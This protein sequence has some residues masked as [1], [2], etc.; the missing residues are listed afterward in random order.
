[1]RDFAKWELTGPNFEKLMKKIR[2]LGLPD[3]ALYQICELAGCSAVRDLKMEQIAILVHL[4]W[5]HF[6]WESK[7]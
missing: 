5:D 3:N 7:P 1:M 2:E 4:A 6:S